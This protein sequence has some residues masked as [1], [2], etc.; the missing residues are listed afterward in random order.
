MRC[1]SRW[2]STRRLFC[3]ETWTRRQRYCQPY[4]PTNETKLRGSWR[5]KVSF[6]ANPPSNSNQ[7][8]SSDQ[9]E[10]ALSVSTDPDHKFDLAIQLDD[11]T[12]ALAIATEIPAPENET[13]WK[14][15]GDRALAAWRFALAKE[16]FEK[17]NDTSSM[18]LLLL[19]MGDRDGL[20]QLAKLAGE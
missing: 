17:A 7:P 20:Q 19:A 11:L 3:G 2:S 16:C 6:A 4:Q 18:M 14:A 12:T 15:V 5:V 9:K 13:K 10:L 8:P 1:H